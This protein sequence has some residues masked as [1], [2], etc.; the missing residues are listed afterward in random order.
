MAR[1]QHLPIGV[2]IMGTKWSDARLINV[3]AAIEY[4]IQGK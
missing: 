2:T 1:I 3:A 4:V